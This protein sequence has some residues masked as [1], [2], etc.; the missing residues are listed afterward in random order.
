MKK[1]LLNVGVVIGVLF[2]LIFNINAV[3]LSNDTIAAKYNG[4]QIDLLEKSVR[5]SI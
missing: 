4:I 1:R 3:N 2:S 5:E